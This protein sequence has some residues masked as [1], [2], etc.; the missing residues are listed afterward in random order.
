MKIAKVLISFS[1]YTD[2][3]FL[4][5]ALFIVTCMTNNLN[6]PTPV[7]TLTDVQ[8]GYDAYSNALNAASALGRQAVLDKN[9]ARETLEDL[10]GQLGRYVMFVANGDESILGSSGFTM[11]KVPQPMVLDSP[12]N[13]TLTNGDNPGELISQVP[14]QN[15]ITFNHQIT[16][17]L[18]TE[19]TVWSSFT[20]STSRFTFRDLVPGKQYWV[21]VA[22]N[23]SRKQIKYSTVGT[24]FA[25]L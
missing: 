4:Q 24:Q 5:K 1:R 8:T 23:G 16:D 19:G 17:V 21:R 25:S 2:A 18:P 20:V 3:D 7:P 10:L 9:I 6:F 22:A 12:G 13:V 15:A 14:K 11:A